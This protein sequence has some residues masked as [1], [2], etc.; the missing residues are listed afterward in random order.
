MNHKIACAIKA[1]AAVLIVAAISSCSAA[2]TVQ[3]F[4]KTGDAFMTALKDGNY[5]QAYSLFVPELQKEVGA[6]SNLQTMIKSN[7]AQPEKWSF[8]SFN[9]ATKNQTQTATMSGNVTYKDGRK[10][11]VTLEMVK[12]GQDWKMTKFNLTW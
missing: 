2:Q 12:V 8:N 10:G 5:E 6:A 4:V 7:N 3:E 11:A 9:V 1:V